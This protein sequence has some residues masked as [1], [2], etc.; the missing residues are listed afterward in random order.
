M[1]LVNISI[2]KGKPP[3]YVK[4]IADGVN[5]AV[6]ETMGFPPDHRYQIIT[7]HEPY[8]SG[9]S[10]TCGRSGHDVPHHAERPEPRRQAPLPFR[11]RVRSLLDQ[12]A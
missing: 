6:I 2:L 3:A 9:A 4:A 12:S 1:P 11:R 7:E 8:G 5:S 10:G